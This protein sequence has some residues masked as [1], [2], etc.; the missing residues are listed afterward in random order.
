MKISRYLSLGGLAL[1]AI[2]SASAQSFAPPTNFGNVYFTATLTSAT[3]GANGDGMFTDFFSSAGQDF[4]VSPAGAFT[5]PVAYTYANTGANTGTITEGS[6]AIALTFSSATGGTFV[7]TYSPGVTQTG[8]FSISTAAQ[9]TPITNTSTLLPLSAGGS[10][11]F[12]FYIG[13]GVPRMVLIRA[14]GPGLSGFGVSNPLATPQLSLWNS[15]GVAMQSGTS[16]TAALQATYGLAGAF[17]LPVGSGDQALV[18]T[19]NPGGYTAQVKAASSTASG[20]VLVE[21]YFLN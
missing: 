1:A 9:G 10:A 13:G 15:S 3:G 14:V 16:T 4:T 2:A 19:L 18:T 20:T 21:V 6:L 17:P 7:A 11:V 5:N 12:G 8:T